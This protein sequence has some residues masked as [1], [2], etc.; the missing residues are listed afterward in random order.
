MQKIQERFEAIYL[1]ES[2]CQVVVPGKLAEHVD[3]ELVLL[4]VV[5]R[6]MFVVVLNSI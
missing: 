1:G 3:S 5:K 4:V 2:L 6:T